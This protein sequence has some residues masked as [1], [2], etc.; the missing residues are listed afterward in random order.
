M[1]AGRT[2]VP[3]LGV[4]ANLEVGRHVGAPNAEA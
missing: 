1:Q 4:L 2:H 3:S